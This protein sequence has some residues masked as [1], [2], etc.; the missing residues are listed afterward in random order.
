MLSV[1]RILF[2]LKFPDIKCEKCA[3]AK[4][5]NFEIFLS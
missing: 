2:K 4:Q 1:E 5:Q 3:V